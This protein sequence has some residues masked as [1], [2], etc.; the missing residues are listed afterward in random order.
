MTNNNIEDDNLIERMLNDPQLRHEVVSNSHMWFFYFYFA[1]YVKSMMA[2]FH[3]KWFEFT[4]NPDVKNAV[5]VAFRGS[6]K[7][8]LFTQS[9]AIWAIL[10]KLQIKHVLIVSRTEKK[11]QARNYEYKTGT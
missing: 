2:P 6:G 7:T 9:F 3:S 5:I 4:E 11:A 1:K 8:S 10:G